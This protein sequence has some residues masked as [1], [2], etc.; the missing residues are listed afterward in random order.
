MLSSC[1]RLIEE[2]GNCIFCLEMS[3]AELMRH[4]ISRELTDYNVIR[5]SPEPLQY[6]L[7][8]QFRMML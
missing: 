3:A 5:T 8:L 4:L 6:R 1:V 7:I 2:E